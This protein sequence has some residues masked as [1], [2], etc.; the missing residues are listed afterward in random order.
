MLVHVSGGGATVRRVW[1]A[2]VPMRGACVL[3]GNRA[4]CKGP[5]P[6][7]G[8]D[9]ASAPVVARL[10]PSNPCRACTQF[11]RYGSP[12]HPR[13]RV[14]QVKSATKSKSL[15]PVWNEVH[16]LFVSCPPD[17]STE[18][19]PSLEVS[20]YDYDMVSADDFMG[21]VTIPLNDVDGRGGT[22][23]D[24][25]WNRSWHQLRNEQGAAGE[26]E[27]GLWWMYSEKRAIDL[28]SG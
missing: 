25:L 2:R 4:A 11:G 21:G 3:G 8:Y 12:L 7:R 5:N 16:S 15:D 23:D 22:L 20:I 27:L 18:P 10:D 6:R 14:C 17:D 1:S 13:S 28:E 19:Y 24:K 26:V 9:R